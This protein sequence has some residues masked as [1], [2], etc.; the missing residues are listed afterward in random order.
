MKRSDWRNAW[1]MENMESVLTWE[2]LA[3]RFHPNGTNEQ[4]FW[5]ASQ[6]RPHQMDDRQMLESGLLLDDPSGRKV[7]IAYVP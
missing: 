7:H 2:D 6:H 4:T 1:L 5:R 3:E